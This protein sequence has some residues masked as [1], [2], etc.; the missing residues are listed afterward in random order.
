MTNFHTFSKNS[1][2]RC[3]TTEKKLDFRMTDEEIN[4][5]LLLF[6]EFFDE[7]Y[8]F[9]WNFLMCVLFL[10]IFFCKT[11][12]IEAQN[13]LVHEYNFQMGRGCQVC[14]F[15]W[16]AGV[17]VWFSI[18]YLWPHVP[19][20]TCQNGLSAR[21]ANFKKKFASDS[22]FSQWLPFDEILE[23]SSEHAWHGKLFHTLGPH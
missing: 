2:N 17:R 9:L 16:T 13:C 12:Q 8:I 6:D 1:R 18:H 15:P 19:R 21:V 10:M 3:C 22:L 20:R 4:F 11:R 23:K 5:K 7:C 14:D